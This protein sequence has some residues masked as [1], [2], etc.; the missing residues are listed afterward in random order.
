MAMT[1]KVHHL[2]PAPGAKT[3]KT[4][5]GR[6]EGVQ[7]QD[8]RSRHQGH[9][10]P[11]PGAGAASRAGR[12]RCTCGCPSCGASRT[13]SGSSTRSS[14]WT[15][16]ASCSRTAA[17]V[18]VDDL[19]AKGAVRKGELVKVLGTGELTRR[20][21]GH[22][23]RVLRRPP[24]RRSPPPA[25]PSPSSS[26]RR[27]RRRRRSGSSLAR[28]A[29][30][31]RRGCYRP[32][33]PTGPSGAPSARVRRQACSPRSRRRSG[34]LTCARSCCSRWRSSRSSGSARTCRPRV[35]PTAPSRPA[36]TRPGNSGVYGLV[37]LF[38]GGALLQLSIFAL[39]IMPYITASII[40]QLLDRGHPAVRGAQEGGPVR[41]GED[42]AVHPL[43]DHRPGGPAVHRPRRARPQPGRLFQRLRRGPRSRT[44][45]STVL[46]I[47][48]I[49]M[50]AGTA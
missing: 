34:R 12:C 18:G 36:S 28:P 41:A 45:R 47:M 1:L 14:T 7:G 6:G 31:G 43:P 33:V 42:H 35:S 15:G 17:T 37:N 26:S 5:V 44:S 29:R 27:S 38:S 30:P 2:R 39:G 11:L 8:R 22:G 24:R 4:R 19:V 49:T 20:A 48:V 32:S 16:S 50:T 40:L 3:A 10:G 25:A 23:A 9:Q 13:R 21:A 46:L